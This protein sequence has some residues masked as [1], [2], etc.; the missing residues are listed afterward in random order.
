VK[1]KVVITE[2]FF[3]TISK[4]QSEHLYELVALTDKKME[5]SEAISA[6]LQNKFVAMLTNEQREMFLRDN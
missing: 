4:E 6:L 5:R 3:E 2:E 1:F